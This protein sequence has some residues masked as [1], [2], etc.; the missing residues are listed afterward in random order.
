MKCELARENIA[1]AVYGEL[2]DDLSHQL[3]PHLA[4][5]AD[6]RKEMEAVRALHAAMSLYPVEEPTP[7]FLAR[8]RL[9]LEEALDSLPH[10]AWLTRLVP[11]FFGTLG[12]LRSSPVLASALLVLGLGAGGFTGYRAGSRSTPLPAH[13]T[14]VAP[15]T[16]TPIAADDPAD[17]ANISS[18]VQQPNSEMVEVHYNRL[19]PG[20][21]E[22]SL[23]DPAIRQLLLL[24][25]RN[26]RGNTGVHQNSVEL[27]AHE[28]RAGHECNSGPVREA[29][30]VALRY[31]Q[32]P[33]VRLKALQGLE[34]YIPQDMRVRDAVLEALMSD[35]DAEV[36]AQAIS[37]VGSVGADSSV[38]QVL[39]TVASQDHN[40]HIRD[41]S[42]QV[43]DQLPQIQ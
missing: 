21:L 9:E 3:E 27:L 26:S 17:V 36:R 29:L 43:L 35:P 5:C 25:A 19:V 15:S 23:D 16:A 41:A 18:I 37:L 24:A 11:A 40:A 10:S 31:D 28:C 42:Q 12:K 6:C 34:A 30:M 2:P 20:S 4:D 38:R 39:H 8:A 7:N 33:T 13:R 14:L 32:S 1:L 22:G